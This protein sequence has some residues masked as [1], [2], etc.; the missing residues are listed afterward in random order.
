MSTIMICSKVMMLSRKSSLEFDP[1]KLVC[2]N[3]SISIQYLEITPRVTFSS[4]CNFKRSILK[5]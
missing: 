2:A 1:L 3:Q 4:L 5:K